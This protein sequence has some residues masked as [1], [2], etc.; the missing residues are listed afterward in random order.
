MNH[1]VLEEPRAPRLQQTGASKG[2]LGHF[3]MGEGWPKGPWGGVS[4]TDAV[5]GLTEAS[6]PVDLG[7]PGERV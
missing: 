6:P 3:Q 1:L 4:C 2:L 5:E 7:L